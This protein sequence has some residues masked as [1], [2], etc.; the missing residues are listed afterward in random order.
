M[1]IPNKRETCTLLPLGILK[2]QMGIASFQ[3]QSPSYQV[4]KINWGEPKSMLCEQERLR[5]QKAIFSQESMR[6][7]IASV[8]PA[9]GD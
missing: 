7:L 3:A 9:R 8:L 5:F 1:H 4:I 2:N 6:W